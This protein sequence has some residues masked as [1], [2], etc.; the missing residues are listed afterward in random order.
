MNITVYDRNSGQVIAELMT[1]STNDVLKFIEKGF[2]VVDNLTKQE[3]T[4]SQ[5]LSMT[6]VSD[7]VI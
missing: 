5:V 1:A 7:C 3:I 2:K 4:E 6:G